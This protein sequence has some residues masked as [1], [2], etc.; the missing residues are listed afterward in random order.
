MLNEKELALSELKK[1][2]RPALGEILCLVALQLCSGADVQLL[3]LCVIDVCVGKILFV[4][5]LAEKKT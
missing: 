3:Y 5:I 2:Y 1:M 4:A